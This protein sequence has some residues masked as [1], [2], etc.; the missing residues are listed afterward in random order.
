M[1]Q[2]FLR[3]RGKASNP[4]FPLPQIQLFESVTAAFYL[5]YVGRSFSNG[6]LGDALHLLGFLRMNERK[7]WLQPRRPVLIH[8][9]VSQ[10][11]KLFPN[12]RVSFSLQV[13]HTELITDANGD[14]LQIQIS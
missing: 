4:N 12:T 5:A 2:N 3:L 14:Q 6:F 13:T 10:A 7:R 9:A 1:T 11:V 8:S